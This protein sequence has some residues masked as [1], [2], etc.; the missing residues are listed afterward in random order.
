[1]VIQK[2]FALASKPSKYRLYSQGKHSFCPRAVEQ[3]GA[4]C[5]PLVSN[6]PQ[7]NP[8]FILFNAVGPLDD[9]W[10]EEE[11]VVELP[12][13]SEIQCLRA[14][15]EALFSSPGPRRRRHRE[16]QM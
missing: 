16:N 2:D 9:G 13:P 10:E 8:E 12:G 14:G 7:S 1:M 4:V 15:E 5:A 3:S 11:V 6:E